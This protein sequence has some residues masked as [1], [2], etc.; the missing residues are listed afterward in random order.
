LDDKNLIIGP[1]RSSEILPVVVVDT[2]RW[3]LISVR[4]TAHPTTLR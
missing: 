3:L 4:S 2:V 1:I